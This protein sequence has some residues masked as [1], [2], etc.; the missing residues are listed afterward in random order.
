MKALLIVL[1]LTTA[2][3]AKLSPAEMY[4]IDNWLATDSRGDLNGDMLCDLTDWAIATQE[5][6]RI[7]VIGGVNPDPDLAKTIW[8]EKLYMAI[9]EAAYEGRWN[10]CTAYRVAYLEATNA[11]N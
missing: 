6:I 10:L 1:L 9:Y 4:V 11:N 2:A 5:D 8:L 3:C 7:C